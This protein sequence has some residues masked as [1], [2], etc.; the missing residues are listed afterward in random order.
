MQENETIVNRR[1]YKNTIDLINQSLATPKDLCFVLVQHAFLP[2]ID[3]YHCIESK[4]ASVIL[5]GSSAKQNP[6]VVD[7]LKQ[8]YGSRVQDCVKRSDLEDSAFTIELLKKTTRGKPFVIL[9]YGAYFAPAI[10]AVCNDPLLGPKLLGVVEGTENGIKGSTDG[11]TIG[12]GTVANR[13]ACPIISKSRSNIK[14]IMDI[15]IGPAIVDAADNILC[16]LSLIHI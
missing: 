5:K 7:S 3:F 14:H 4:L 12:Y 6:S 8:R 2:S 13:V 9:E 15:E 10:T 11:K 16:N 1:Y